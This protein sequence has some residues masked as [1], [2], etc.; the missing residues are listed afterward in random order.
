V[1]ER[2]TR[3]AFDVRGCVGDLTCLECIDFG[4]GLPEG[5]PACEEPVPLICRGSFPERLE[6]EN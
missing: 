3:P 2:R 4:F 6:E 5:H 1:D